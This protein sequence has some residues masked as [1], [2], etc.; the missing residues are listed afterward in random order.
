MISKEIR[1]SIKESMLCWLATSG[2][3]GIPNCT[4]KEAFTSCGDDKIVIAN[5]ASPESV[6]NIKSNP[7]VCVSFIDIF[8]QKGFKLKGTALY[9]SPG[10]PDYRNY[11]EILRPI[12]GSSFPIK[13]IIVVTVDKSSHIIAPSYYMIPGTTEETKIKQSKKAYGV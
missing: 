10:D 7:N 6:K 5:I 1:E 11:E 3:G 13:G 4:P 8:R 2:Q 9:L 12:I